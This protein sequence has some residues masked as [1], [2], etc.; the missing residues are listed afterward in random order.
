MFFAHSPPMGELDRSVELIAHIQ[1]RQLRL[2]PDRI[3]S[4]QLGEDG[5]LV[6]HVGIVARFLTP[7]PEFLIIADAIGSGWE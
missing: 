3:A 2:S 7:E 6:F 5:C 4:G 1:Q